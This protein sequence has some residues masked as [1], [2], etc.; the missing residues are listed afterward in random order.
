MTM[1]NLFEWMLVLIIIVLLN[2]SGCKDNLTKAPLDSPSDVTFFRSQSDLE[3]AINGAYTSLW[4][5]IMEGIPTL[6][7][8]DNGTDIGFLRQDEHGTQSVAQ[9]N[10]TPDTE[11]FLRTWR[12]FYSGISKVNNVL[13][14]MDKAQEAVSEDFFTRIQAE[15]RLWWILIKLLTDYP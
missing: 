9:G 13:N 4:W 3:L 7:V 6:Q 8:I 14:N 2:L 5:E 15:A 12:H 11:V 1:K 10:H